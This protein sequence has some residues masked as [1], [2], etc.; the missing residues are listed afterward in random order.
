M[1]QKAMRKFF[2]PC[3]ACQS[4]GRGLAVGLHMQKQIY[5]RMGAQKKVWQ[6]AQRKVWK[7]AQK[8]VQ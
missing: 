4:H 5:K 6:T 8:I 7:V 3:F 2:S 1:L